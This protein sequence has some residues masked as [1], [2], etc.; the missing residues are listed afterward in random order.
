M[1]NIHILP[2]DKPILDGSINYILKCIKSFKLNRQYNIGDTLNELSWDFD[3]NYW[4]PQHIYITSNEE[5]K[6]KNWCLYL[7]LSIT[8]FKVID[9][10]N[11]KLH[12]DSRDFFN[13][14]IC[15]KIILTTDP[16]LIKQGVQAI[17]DKFLEWFIKNPSCEE[18]EWDKNYNRGNGKYYYK[19]I[20]PKEETKCLYDTP[21]SCENSQCRVQNKCNGDKVKPKQE[22]LEEAAEK[23]YPF[24]DG[25]QVMDI[26]ISEM[27]QLAF[28]NGAKWQAE[29]D[30]NKF[31]E[32]EVLEIFKQYNDEKFGK[33]FWAIGNFLKWFKQFKKQ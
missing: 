32:E 3:S 11:Y 23:R 33:G 6:N 14:S 30:K 8:F 29:Q 15:K 31:S 25:F 17:P 26:D 27:L 9:I 4:K 2:T 28:I 10:D 22:T 5:I 18:V 21:K 13:K 12:Y 20:I 1:R 16:D 7:G 24:E 19:I